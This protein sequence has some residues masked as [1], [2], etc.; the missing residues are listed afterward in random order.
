MKKT[1]LL[2]V[3]CA[4][5]F[6]G[7]ACTKKSTVEGSGGKKLTLVAPMNQTVKQGDTN[8]VDFAI[9]RTNFDDPVEIEI[10]NLPSGVTVAQGNRVTIPSGK[11]RVDGITLVAS[12]D[13]T[14]VRDHQVSVTA[15]GPEGIAVTEYFK[16][17]VEPK[18]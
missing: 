17:T 18:S 15:K 14:L 2:I 11:L 13:A 6:A 4:L 7:A 5:A 1:S 8:K 3:L 16:V 12:S 10:S 9:V